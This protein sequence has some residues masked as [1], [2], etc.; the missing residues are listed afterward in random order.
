MP[1]VLKA[2]IAERAEAYR[3]DYARYY[4]EWA[5]S[6]SPPLRDANPSVVI[7]PGLGIFGFGRNKKEARITTE[8]FM[9]AIH[10][11]AGANALEEGHV[12]HPLSAG[13]APAASRSNS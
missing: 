8:F 11:M 1:T 13:S 7:I 6:D 2:L 5:A 3:A 12:S 4:Q 9:N 10:V